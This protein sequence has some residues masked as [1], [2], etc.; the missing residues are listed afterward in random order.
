MVSSQ[1]LAMSGEQATINFQPCPLALVPH[2]LAN[3]TVG[4]SIRKPQLGMLLLLPAMLRYALHIDHYQN[5]DWR[6]DLK[7]DTHAQPRVIV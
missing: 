2:S 5:R 6:L 1:R 4:S 7:S 3:T